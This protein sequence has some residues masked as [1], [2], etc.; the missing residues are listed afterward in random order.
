MYFSLRENMMYSV[1]A[2]F[3][4]GIATATKEGGVFA[5]VQFID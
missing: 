2:A 3:F 5:N 1:R 4:S